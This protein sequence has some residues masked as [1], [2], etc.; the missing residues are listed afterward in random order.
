MEEFNYQEFQDKAADVIQELL[1][2]V[3]KEWKAEAAGFIAT[4][5]VIFGAYNTFEG[6]GIFEM[7]KLEYLD[8]C[9]DVLDEENDESDVYLN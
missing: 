7:S 5:A 3:P 2:T 9:N 8:I 6:M 1:K 4:E